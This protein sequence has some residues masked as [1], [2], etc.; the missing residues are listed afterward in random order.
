MTTQ[1]SLGLLCWTRGVNDL[2]A[3]NTLFAIFVTHSIA[4]HAN[5]DW[6]NL[7]D[8]DIKE[9]ELGLKYGYRLMSVYDFGKD[10][11]KI[12]IITEADRSY[13]TVLFPDEY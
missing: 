10:Q 5:C 7:D 12:W 9:N 6:G 13:T 8:H 4:R 1:F 11:I 3:E 2:I